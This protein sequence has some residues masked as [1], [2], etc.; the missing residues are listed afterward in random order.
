M[1]LRQRECAVRTARQQ[2]LRRAHAP[3]SPRSLSPSAR[4]SFLVPRSLLL[5]ALLIL[6]ACSEH[7]AGLHITGLRPG[8][9]DRLEMN[10][11]VELPASVTR[12]LTR[13]V[14]L[15]FLCDIDRPAER[16]SL[17]RELRFLPL[18]RQYQLREPA[19][20]YSRSYASRSAALAALERWPLPFAADADTPVRARVYLDRGRLPSPLALSSLFDRDWHLDSG[21]VAWPAGRH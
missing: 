9:D 13:G 3:G 16:S 2:P 8:V 15:N 18:S 6:A 7:D 12:G 11:R 10:L 20:G 19:S 21:V 14:P 1:A 5:L 17:R 4:S